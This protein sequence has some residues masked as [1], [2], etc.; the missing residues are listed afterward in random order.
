[1][2]DKWTDDGR[3]DGR[4]HGRKDTMNNNAALATSYHIGK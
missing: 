1:M 4:T 2:T 3:M